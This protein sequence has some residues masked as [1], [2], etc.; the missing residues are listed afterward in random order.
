MKQT[1]FSWLFQPI[2]E[3]FARWQLLHFHLAKGLD[4]V[5]LLLRF[6]QISTS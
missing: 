5:T 4:N 3:Q 1:N 2:M 6:R